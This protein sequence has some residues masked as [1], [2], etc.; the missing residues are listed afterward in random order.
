MNEQRTTTASTGDV[1]DAAGGWLA[2]GGILTMALFPFAI[3]GI[4]LTVAAL[5]PLL[6][7]ALVAGL[8]AAVAAAPILAVRRFRQPDGSA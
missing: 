7:L 4:V 8:V 5:V 1:I 2:A 3:P 6:L